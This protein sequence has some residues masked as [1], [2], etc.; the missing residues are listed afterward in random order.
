[1]ALTCAR[2]GGSVSLNC[3]NLPVG[4]LKGTL[5]IGNRD[6][7]TFT[8]G[9]DNTITGVTMASGTNL[10]KWEGP[11]A[12]SFLNGRYEQRTGN[13]INGFGHFIDA[14]LLEDDQDALTELS[15]M[16]NA[17]LVAILIKESYNADPTLRVYGNNHGLVM[18]EIAGDETGADNEGLPGFVL[19]TPE[20]V[21]EALAP[22]HLLITDYDATITALDA[23]L[24]A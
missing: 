5:Y 8:V 21:K 24:P 22:Q 17:K 16:N 19:S 4:R 20:G 12:N 11:E 7:A 6:D 13:L 3:D 1:M 23:L 14:V 18:T 10:Y 9:A 2:L 15:N